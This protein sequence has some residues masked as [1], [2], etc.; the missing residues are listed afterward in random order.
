MYP[1]GVWAGGGRRMGDGIYV[2]DGAASANSVA[3]PLS[4]SLFG[5][6][7]PVRAQENPGR[8]IQSNGLPFDGGL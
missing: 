1:G 3:A 2:G 5:N 6:A 8:L 4:Q 7:R